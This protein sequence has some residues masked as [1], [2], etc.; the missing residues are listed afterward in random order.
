MRVVAPAGLIAERYRLLSPLGSGSSA[1]VWAAADET[2]GRQVA[3]KL[4][5]APASADA[6]EG[7]EADRED[8]D[9]REQLRREA[10]ALAALTHPHVI[11]VFDF[12]ETPGFDGAVQPVLVTELLEG[13]SMAERLAEGP[14]PW[15][16]ALSV[17]GQLASALATAHRAGIV[18]R[19]VAPGNVM[20]TGSG[21]NSGVKLLDFGLAKAVTTA[22]DPTDDGMT[23]GTPVCMAPEQLMGLGA[24]P[25][26]D[27]YGFGCVLHWCLTGRPPYR[28]KDIVWLSQSHLRAEPPPLEID[29]LPEG[30]EELYLACLAKEPDERPS[31]EEAAAMLAPYAPASASASLSALAAAA[32]SGP[33][34]AARHASARM[35]SAATKFATASGDRRSRA[36][37]AT[38][39]LPM[40][41]ADGV[42]TYV[43]PGTTGAATA[44]QPPPPATPAPGRHAGSARPV[45]RSRLL[46]LGVLLAA[47]AIIALMTFGLVQTMDGTGTSAAGTSGAATGSAAPTSAS[48]ATAT[49]GSVIL[50]PGSSAAAGASAS[51]SASPTASGSGAA[52]ASASASPSMSPSEAATTSAALAPL[53]DPA[54]DP[55]G[56]VQGLRNQ[57][58]ALI[59]QGP[60]T[61]QPGAGQNLLNSLAGLQNLV[62]AARQHP[63]SKQWRDV[64]N[65][66]TA[67]Q[68]QV[69]N[70]AS[71][72]QISAS[73]ANTLVSEL[74]SLADSLP[75]TNT[76]GNG[77]GPGN[78]D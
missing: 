53:P 43:S 60:A 69:S 26:S 29:G 22:K 5:S 31:A 32:A 63:G 1:T 58:Q 18:H 28:D 64:A 45:D 42:A 55:V 2:L 72:G 23:V 8:G 34:V 11:V 78:G 37:D 19:D 75:G 41:V 12:L 21:D 51:A 57:V 36:E 47:L 74:Q 50:P 52:S 73:A 33:P 77:N 10:R 13:R 39:L 9:V 68:Q 30:I 16:E 14:L 76:N 17:C 35:Y 6:V 3:L 71:A 54:A 44:A 40:V 4:L 25:A 65:R 61:L 66:V 48:S 20:L 49:V 24:L 62:A 70:A 38:E 7:D 46:P 59:A 27:V 56:Y 15:P 67:I